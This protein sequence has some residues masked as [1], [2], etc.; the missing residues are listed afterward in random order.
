MIH[1][2]NQR[3]LIVLVGVALLPAVTRAGQTGSELIADMETEPVHRLKGKPGKP[4]ATITGITASQGNRSL[5]LEYDGEAGGRGWV[6]FPVDGADG[7]NAV[8]FDIYCESDHGAYL[9]VSVH[10]KTEGEGTAAVFVGSLNMADYVDG[11]T[12]VRVVKDADLVFKQQGGVE[13]DWSRIV[14]VRFS[15]KCRMK[16]KVVYFLDNVRFENVTGG[17]EPPNQLYNSSFEITTNPDVPDGWTRDSNRPPFGQDAWGIDTNTAYHGSKSLR[18]GCIKKHALSWTRHTNVAEGR[19]YTGSVYLK[20]D[21]N[22][23]EAR[24]T[25]SGIGE[26]RVRLTPEWKRYWV[27]GKAKRSV[28]TV[29]IRLISGGTLWIDAVQFEAG[30]SPTPYA[31]SAGDTVKLDETV[32][33]VSAAVGARP[34]GLKPPVV[35]IRQTGEP[36]SVDGN[37]VENCWQDAEGMTPFVKLNTNEPARRVTVAKMCYNRKALYFA[38]IAEEPDMTP[39]ADLF[40]DSTKGLWD[41]D[42][43]EIL[44]DFNHD[45][46]SCYHF[47]ANAKG[48]RKHAR[49]AAKKTS[50]GM[51]G[52]WQCDWH[53]AGQIGTNGWT[54]EVEIPY[55]CFDMRPFMKIGDT[56]G[57]NICRED[58]RNSEHSSWAF[59]YGSFRNPPAFGEAKGFDADLRPYRLEMADLTWKRGVAAATVRNHTGKDERLGFSFVAEGPDEIHSA[60]AEAEIKAGSEARVTAPLPLTADGS[61]LLSV[62]TSDDAGLVR[63]ASQPTSV[64]ITGAAILD[65]VGTEYDFYTDEPQARA[66]CFIEAGRER[67]E[68]LRL[69]WWTE[70]EGSERTKPSE[71]RL[72]PG[73]NEW[74]IPITGLPNGRHLLKT[75][76]KKNGATVA[77]HE[78][79]FRK[80]PPAKHE[81]RINQWGRFLVCDG[82]PFFWYG[83]YDGLWGN[84]DR[85]L[86][87]LKEMKSAHCT[88]TL[89]YVSRKGF[90]SVGWALDQAQ[91][92]G[93]K[94]WVHLG[95]MLVY[96]I[97]KYEKSSGRYTNEEEAV[98]HLTEIVTRYKEHPA[99]LGWC[100]IDEPGN[101]RHFFTKEYTERYY[102]LI[103]KLDPYHP[104]IFSHLT[105]LGE[106]DT[107]G[108]ATD[109]VLMP[110]MA[111]VGRYDRLFW[112]SW[113]AGFAIAAN[114]PCG[115]G[116]R[117]PTPAEQRIRMYKPIIMGARGICSFIFRCASMFTWREFQRVGE[118]LQTLA[119]ILLTPDDRLRVDVEPG[120]RDVFALLKEHRGRHYLLAVNTAPHSVEATFRLVDVPGIGEVIPMFGSAAAEVDSSANK[121]RVTMGPQTTAFYRCQP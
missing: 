82:Q 21:R 60:S 71:L 57:V 61:Y 107:Y 29:K 12:S 47:A 27:S 76:V 3:I 63:L 109:M 119:P 1:A 92:H 99:L 112:E 80:L 103:K 5:R 78:R 2:V 102:R 83:F 38:V 26:K 77:E 97:P 113:D 91:A 65:L 51:S 64:R 42:L 69:Y 59:S 15:T 52:T 55:T 54:V 68:N 115:V 101:R 73:I 79:A 75:A 13:P 9:E 98:A 85:W 28:T 88:A 48:Q 58:P 108:G 90:D 23:T 93:V 44:I 31:P 19:D 114:P 87:A 121:L 104:C 7:Y 84:N 11:W 56:I 16:G 81:V 39:V 25:V 62:R 35:H 89:N 14:G 34:E 17:R 74:E 105:R 72:K 67:C 86:A 8:S 49:Y 32:R 94:Q 22:E 36:V 46:K 120:G 117:G 33:R 116:R 106:V 41:N 96:W 53:A 4:K 6:T 10:Q 66:R 43:I 18:I 20:G 40:R 111:R 30:T 50:S 110:F 95:W 45:R 24:V 100:S 70:H 118:E 37:L